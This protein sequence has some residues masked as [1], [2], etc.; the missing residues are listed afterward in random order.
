MAPLVMEYLGVCV[1]GNECACCSNFKILT[2]YTMTIDKHF[3]IQN[4]Y[5]KGVLPYL[6]ASGAIFC[7]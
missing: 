5:T 4:I 7:K 6:E 3:S 2:L 1:C